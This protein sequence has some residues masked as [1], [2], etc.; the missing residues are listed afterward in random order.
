M[1][2]GIL[3]N[4]PLGL[5]SQVALAAATGGAS[6]LV[7]VAF[8]T[9]VSS[10]GQQV[11][12]QLGREMGLPQGLID[13]AQGAFAGAVGDYEGATANYQ[14]AVDSFTQGFGGSPVEGAEAQN[15]ADILNRMM[16]D[17]ARNARDS[18]ELRALAGGKGGGGSL[19]M[20]IAVA[21]GSLMDQKMDQM[22]KLTT[23]IGGLGTIDEKN[24]SKMGE[25]TGKLQGLSQET[26]MLSN[27]LS[28]SIK[29]IGEAGT[30]LARKGG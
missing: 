13:T 18:E 24:Q 11:I 15:A 21:L 16:L 20:R 3:G 30:T 25:L 29:T 9:V 2:G 28:N 22:D 5:V 12:Q 19:L 17:G 1:F 4:G 6:T 23:Q 26:N 14:E 7:Q 8:R 10:I 27:A